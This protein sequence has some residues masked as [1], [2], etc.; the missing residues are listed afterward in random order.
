[1]RRPPVG[2]SD[3][4]NAFRL[5]VVV[6]AQPSREVTGDNCE[7][8]LRAAALICALDTKGSSA[9]SGKDTSSG[10]AQ[11]SGK[12]L[13]SGQGLSSGRTVSSKRAKEPPVHAALSIPNPGQLAVYLGVGGGVDVGLLPNARPAA[14]LRGAMVLE[15]FE[16]ALGV[17]VLLPEDTES[18]AVAARYGAGDVGLQVGGNFVY[19]RVQLRGAESASDR[20]WR[21]RTNIGAYRNVRRVRAR[22]G[23]VC[24]HAHRPVRAL[25]TVG[26]RG[27]FC[28]DRAPAL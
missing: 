10:K 27:I 23:S 28:L 11:S 12:A 7:D 25:G 15:S 2:D 8:L 24:R 6:T 17:G 21:A 18:N 19:G 14:Y 20:D 1:M 16:I 3:A 4:A 9:V 22:G 5:N 26:E 13:S